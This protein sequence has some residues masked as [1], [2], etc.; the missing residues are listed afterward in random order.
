MKIQRLWLWQARGKSCLT[1]SAEGPLL[2]CVGANGRLG[3]D[4]GVGAAVVAA[5]AVVVVVAA[6]DHR[7]PV[8]RCRTV[9]V[10]LSTYAS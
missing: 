2:R 4:V 10:D 6:G 1:G 3:S 5:A 7:R 9:D 8:M